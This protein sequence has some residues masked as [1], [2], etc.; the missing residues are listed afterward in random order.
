[1]LRSS[2]ML[3]IFQR[4]LFPCVSLALFCF[5]SQEHHTSQ[6]VFGNP[7]PRAHQLAI[8]SHVACIA[9]VSQSSDLAVC[10]QGKSGHANWL[11]TPIGLWLKL[12]IPAII[13]A[14]IGYDMSLQFRLRGDLLLCCAFALTA[15]LQ[16]AFSQPNHT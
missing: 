16:A 10:I 11:A 9:L 13:G 3:L 6:Q 4:K 14:H 2:Y 12:I 15:G 8:R 1:M 7:G 5:R